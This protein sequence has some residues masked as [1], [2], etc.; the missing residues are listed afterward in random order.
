[1]DLASVDREVETAKQS[2]SSEVTFNLGAGAEQV[3]LYRSHRASSG[4]S[5]LSSQLLIWLRA[6][7]PQAQAP[8]PGLHSNER[9]AS[10]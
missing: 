6:G 8:P 2:L 7:G 4:G 10:Q 5:G 3:A 9:Q 1:M